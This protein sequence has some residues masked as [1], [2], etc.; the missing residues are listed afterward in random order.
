MDQDLK[1]NSQRSTPENF[2]TRVVD[3]MEPPTKEISDPTLEHSPVTQPKQSPEKSD[4][5]LEETPLSTSRLNRAPFH[6][7]YL[8]DKLSHEYTPCKLRLTQI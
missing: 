5:E 7:V 6:N 4:F 3:Q 1:T 8:I 2:R